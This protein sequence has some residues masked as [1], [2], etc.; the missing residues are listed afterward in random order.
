[1]YISRLGNLEHP[2][3]FGNVG[4]GRRFASLGEEPKPKTD[5][6]AEKEETARRVKLATSIIGAVVMFAIVSAIGYSISTGSDS[7]F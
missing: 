7:D 5:K 6:D 1:M 4:Q 2:Q 3:G